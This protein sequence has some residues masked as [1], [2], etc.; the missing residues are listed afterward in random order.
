MNLPTD[1]LP[2]R[3]PLQPFLPIHAKILMLGSFPPQGKRWSM[4]FFYPNI[5]NDMWRIFGLI[6]F[7]DKEYFYDRKEKR[8]IMKRLVAFLEER[9]I[10]LYDTA[11]C[12][13][14]LKNNASD[15][16]LEIIE[17]TDIHSLLHRI[18]QCKAVIATGEKA[19][20]VVARQF[21]LPPLTIGKG[22]KT[23]SITFY[24]MP[25]SSRSYPL[26]L[27]KKATFY[28]QAFEQTVPELFL[29]TSV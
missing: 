18:P 7:Q 4:P 26:P 23:P 9:G 6:F 16:H 27:E 20:T 11:T 21:N 19:A 14:R 24:R 1:I 13:K 22:I 28:Q 29:P 15:A 5:Q 3:H 10:A 12:V 2:E 17:E 8:F 25:S